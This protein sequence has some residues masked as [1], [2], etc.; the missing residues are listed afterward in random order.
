TGMDNVRNVIGC[1]VAGL[2]PRELFDASPAAR[3]FT[4]LFVGSRAYTN[5]PRKF[6][7][8]ITGCPENCVGAESQ[9]VAMVPARKGE[10]GGRTRASGRRGGLRAVARAR[11]RGR[12]RPEPDRPRRHLPA[13]GRAQL[14]RRGRPRR[15]GDRRAARRGGTSRGHLR[16]R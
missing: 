6:N 7:V 11:R 3:E 10:R 2:T 4:R 8:A 14:R 9:D 13:E 12:A 15:P 16:Q 1:P 5:L